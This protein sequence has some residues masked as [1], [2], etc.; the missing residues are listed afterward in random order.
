MIKEP[1]EVSISQLEDI[2]DK[3]LDAGSRVNYAVKI[4]GH[5]GTGKSAIVRQVAEAK[6]FQF[7]DTRLAFK[8][9]IDLGGYPVPD[10]SDRRMLYYRP[11]F[12]P[13]ETV[14]KEHNG[15]LW[16]LDESNRAHPTV[17]QT[18][19]Q[20]ITEKTCGEH[21]LPK[22]TGIVLSGN[23]GE[24]DHTT[25]TEFDDSALDARL[26]IFHLKPDVGEWLGWAVA[27]DIH[28]A[29]V[30]YISLFPENLWD[31]KNVYPNPRGWH[32]VSNAVKHAYC[33]IDANALA[34]Y[35]KDHAGNSLEKVI[36]SLI[37]KIAAR[38]FI[39]Q[40]TTPRALTSHDIVSGSVD[41]LARLKNNKVP[42]EDLLWALAG[43]LSVI[44]QAKESANGP[45]PNRDLE[46][47]AHFLTFVG[48]SRSDISISFFYFLIKECGIFTEIPEAL[49]AINDEALIWELKERFAKLLET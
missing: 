9:N 15:I 8:E 34:S 5:P 39:L 30:S 13:P 40:H 7:I 3:Y 36:T 21:K 2:L 18:L 16:F 42:S 26:A 33:L 6:N 46:K 1:V 10:H 28:P 43:A 31:E 24:A 23:L 29:V 14:P 47:L 48:C 17:I 11:R 44:R 4:V 45:L 22:N 12:I 32:Q 38:D 27:E 20:I 19:F 37:G 35:L 41:G 25:I 49:K